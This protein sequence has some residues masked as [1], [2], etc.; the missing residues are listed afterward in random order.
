VI[1]KPIGYADRNNIYLAPGYHRVDTAEGLALIAHEVAHCRQY[2]QH[3]AWR[4]RAKY[5]AAYF[6]NRRSGMPHDQAYLKIPFEIEARVVERKVYAA[7]SRLQSLFNS[8]S[9]Q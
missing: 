5:L 1:A 4:F 7:M 2:Q 9:K 3:G 6:K 8:S